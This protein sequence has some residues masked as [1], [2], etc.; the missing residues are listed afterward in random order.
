MHK[1]FRG[2][3]THGRTDRQ[4]GQ[5][6][7]VLEKQVLSMPKVLIS[8]LSIEFAATKTYI[9]KILIFFP[10]LSQENTWAGSRLRAPV[11]ATKPFC[12]LAPG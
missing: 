4:K 3:Q 1:G 9:S 2:S 12:V 11:T 5:R 7:S 8:W 10:F 6:I